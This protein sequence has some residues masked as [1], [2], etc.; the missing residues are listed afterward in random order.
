[1][2][3]VLDADI[4]NSPNYLLLLEIGVEEGK[5]IISIEA[6]S[7]IFIEQIIEAEMAKQIIMKI[8]EEVD[9]YDFTKQIVNKLCDLIHPQ[10]PNWKPDCLRGS[11]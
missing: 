9:D 2:G 10:Y 8:D 5:M 11:E 4:N 1:V 3:A 7:D 6:D